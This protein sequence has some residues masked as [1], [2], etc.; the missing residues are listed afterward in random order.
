[1][2]FVC[3]P[4]VICKIQTKRDG[5]K[6]YGAISPLAQIQTCPHF[7]A[8]VLDLKAWGIRSSRIG[9]RLA[10][11][12]NCR[13]SGASLI[14]KIIVLTHA[15]IMKQIEGK[16]EQLVAEYVTFC[17]QPYPLATLDVLVS[18]SKPHRCWSLRTVRSQGCLSQTKLSAIEGRDKSL[19]GKKGKDIIGKTQITIVS[20]P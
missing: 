19:W 6:C 1:M 15:S 9:T 20:Q 3:L 2:K 17:R 16:G 7:R 5:Y 11:I 10:I 14:N 13:T 12:A 8:L 18:L 4:S